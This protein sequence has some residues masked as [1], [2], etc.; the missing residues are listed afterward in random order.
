MANQGLHR[1]K[2]IQKVLLLW[3]RIAWIY[4]LYGLYHSKG[5]SNL[6]GNNLPQL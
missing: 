1:S 5:L 4:E 3:E 2:P 6:K